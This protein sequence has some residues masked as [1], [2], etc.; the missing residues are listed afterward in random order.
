MLK[1]VKRAFR[2]TFEVFLW[3]NAVFCVI[4]G[5]VGGYILGSARGGFSDAEIVWIIVG[6]TGGLIL[7]AIVGLLTNVIFGGLIAIFLDIGNDVAGVKAVN[8][9]IQADIATLKGAAADIKVST[10]DTATVF[11]KMASRQ[12]P[13]AAGGQA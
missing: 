2:V 11:Q 1:F 6:L 8:A 7:G 3:L 5:A 4:Y 13:A 10:A 12:A 9:K